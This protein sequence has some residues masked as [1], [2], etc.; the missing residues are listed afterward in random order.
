MKVIKESKIGN[1]LIFAGVLSFA[2][3][4]DFI[5]RQYHI[6][7]AFWDIILFPLSVLC[8]LYFL[9]NF[10][11]KKKR[12]GLKY[13]GED[14]T[15]KKVGMM[16]ASLCLFLP[17]GIG[18]FWMGATELLGYL[19]GRGGAHGYTLIPLGILI[20]GFSIIFI[21]IIVGTLLSKNR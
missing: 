19:S 20:T 18:S 7:V 10:L 12:E 21:Y 2:L 13:L 17:L 11:F 9:K 1:A 14:S 5:R 4:I 6:P 3:S 15:L 8:I 16:M